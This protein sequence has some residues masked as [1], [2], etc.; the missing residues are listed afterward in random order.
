MLNEKP[1]KKHQSSWVK[2]ILNTILVLVIIG[3]LLWWQYPNILHHIIEPHVHKQAN[4]NSLKHRD[5]YD[6]N[7]DKL[8]KFVDATGVN[9]NGQSFGGFNQKLEDKLSQL[10]GGAD[11]KNPDLTYDYGNVKPYDETNWDTVNP[12]YDSRLLVGHIRI[13]AIHVNLPILEGLSNTNLYI[14]AG[15]MKPYQKL[16]QG[17]YAL[18]SHHMPD[19][20]SN[21]SQLGALRK[22]NH[23]YMSS[24]KY[25]YDYKVDTVKKMPT[26]SGN[27][28]ND[29]PGKKMVTLVTCTDIHATARVVVQGH[30]VKKEPIK[31]DLGQ[32]Y[33]K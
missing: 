22:G 15:T 9:V 10:N 3:G 16:G 7:R 29:V 12:K 1:Q 18:A 2:W 32:R 21:F 33:F 31:G 14:G 24:S 17:N 13:P 26:N 30:F 4:E 8:S 23:V 20:Y 25:V 19:E 28:V 6:S 27:V 11:K 5:D